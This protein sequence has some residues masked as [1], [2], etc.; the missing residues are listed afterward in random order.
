MTNAQNEA[1]SLLKIIHT[2]CLKY[3][4]KY[5]LAGSSLINYE[6]AY[7]EEYFSP[8]NIM[9]C[10][11]YKDYIELLDKLHIH[12]D[13]YKIELI[14]SHTAKNFDSLSTWIVFTGKSLL[15]KERKEDEIYYKTRV[16]ITPIFYG[17][18]DQKECEKSCNYIKVFFKYLNSRMPL[19]H[20]RI[21]SKNKLGRM[22]QRYYCVRKIKKD[23]T[24][25]HLI[26]KLCEKDA[27][28]KY[29]IFTDDGK[30]AAWLRTEEF[31]VENISFYGCDAYAIVDRKEFIKR[32]Y[33]SIL[34][35]GIDPVSDLLLCGGRDLRRIQL[36]QL[37]MLK[38]IDR[39]CRKHHLKYNIAF[40]T[41]LGAVRHGG[42]IPWDDDADI[43]MPYEDYVKLIEVID[44]E[45]D[46]EKYYFRYQNKEDDCNITYAHLKRNGTVYTKKGRSAFKYHPGIYIDIVPLFNGAPNLFLHAVQ[47]RICWTLRTACWAYMGADSEKKPLKKFYYKQLAKIGN[48]RA[49]ELFIKAATF[50]KHRRNKMLFLN[51]MDRS[52]YNIGFAKRV[53]FDDPIEIEFEGYKFYAP[54]DLKGVLHYCYGADYMQYLPMEKRVPKNDVL[55]DIGDL[56][57]DI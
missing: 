12:K 31:V 5:T 42:F 8:N 13:D 2:V 54:R 37:D 30:T 23:M 48:K 16:V 15:P 24:F 52:P 43:N 57:K 21:F 32:N 44:D 3:G 46:D 35:K 29:L 55:I 51:G 39:I 10:L 1:L 20:K 34:K 14:N 9:I 7:G 38:E 45:I 47:T 17:G 18:V 22:K 6:Y 49:Y 53:C 56:Y 33:D 26:E 19:P 4:L 28:S 40:G 41:L 50:F 36:V 11:L 27:T 25:D